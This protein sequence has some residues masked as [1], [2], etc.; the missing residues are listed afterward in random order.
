MAATRAVL[1]SL[2]VNRTPRSLALAAGLLAL[3]TLAMTSRAAVW[4]D[5]LQN[6]AGSYSVYA[7]DRLLG[8]ERF[9]L[10]PHGDSVVVASNVDETIPT[11]TGDQ[12]L[13]KKVAL[14]FGALDYG[15]LNYTSETQWRGHFLRR[16]I[17]PSDTTFTSYHEDNKA[18]YGDTGA[19]PPGRFFVIEPQAFVMFDVLLRGLHGKLLGERNLPV[20]MIREPTDTVLEIKIVPGATETIR[21]NNRPVQARRMTLTDG[22]GSF[23]AW[24][25]TKG[26][27]LRLEEPLTGLRVE[28]DPPASDSTA[29]KQP[30]LKRVGSRPS[31]R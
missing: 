2:A 19:R 23:T 29:A 27:M 16:G 25:S 11:P 28:R 20:V 9:V 8:S 5:P 13:E 4:L 10:E 18:G 6:D 31:G 17:V 30:P 26:R 22:T 21:W 24:V 15:I 1:R 14:A 7:R 12:R 3:A